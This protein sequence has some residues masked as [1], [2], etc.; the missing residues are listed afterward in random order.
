MGV[1]P[2]LCLFLF[3]A[4][5]KCFNETVAQRKLK[6][7][8]LTL[9]AISSCN[10]FHL[11]FC[12]THKVKTLSKDI[13]PSRSYQVCHLFCKA[14]AVWWTKGSV[15][16]ASL[17]SSAWSYDLLWQKPFLLLWDELMNP[18]AHSEAERERE[19]PTASNHPL[20]VLSHIYCSAR[21]CT[22]RTTF[23][24]LFSHKAVCT[25]PQMFSFLEGDHRLRS[26]VSCLVWAALSFPRVT[27]ALHFTLKQVKR[28]MRCLWKKRLKGADR[29]FCQDMCFWTIV[30][31][32][33]E[34]LRTVFD[35][36]RWAWGY[37]TSLKWH[38]CQFL[39]VTCFTIMHTVVFLLDSILF[40]LK[41][42]GIPQGSILCP[43]QFLNYSLC[44]L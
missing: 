6:K 11:G 2:L 28:L 16:V 13:S 43:L 15:R 19:R 14:A 18:K 38:C 32:Q 33:Q 25:S 34:E 30:S 12:E 21:S 7:P 5:G 10:T 39:F 44:F 26:L 41:A 22:P 23:S 4:K 1:P 17:A 36:F 37:L 31:K 35:I 9:G 20:N 29:D 42:C 24:C 8:H 40:P 27:P 3:W